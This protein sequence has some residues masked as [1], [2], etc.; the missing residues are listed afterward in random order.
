MTIFLVP[1]V[2]KG[3]IQAQTGTCSL[4]LVPSCSP[5]SAAQQPCSGGGGDTN[6]GSGKA[7]HGEEASAQIQLWKF[8]LEMTGFSSHF[9][10]TLEKIGE[11]HSLIYCPSSRE[12]L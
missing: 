1:K 5:A 12:L 11:A 10:T 7:L 6:K 3:L 4:C 2:C 8:Y 9:Y